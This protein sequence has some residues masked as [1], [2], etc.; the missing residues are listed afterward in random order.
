LAKKRRLRD[1]RAIAEEIEFARINATII[2]HEITGRLQCRSSGLVERVRIC[3][4]VTT[5][6][7]MPGGECDDVPAAEF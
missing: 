1:R 5:A 4:S 6:G 7:K 3:V 2:A